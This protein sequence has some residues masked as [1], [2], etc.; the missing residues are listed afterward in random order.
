MTRCLP[1]AG[2]LNTNRCRRVRV[3]RKILRQRGYA[4]AQSLA[5]QALF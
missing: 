5:A 1:V 4:L 2:A 3:V